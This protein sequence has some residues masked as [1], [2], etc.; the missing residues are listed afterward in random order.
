MLVLNVGLS[1][2]SYIQQPSVSGY[3]GLDVRLN[4][5]RFTKSVSV[6]GVALPPN[7]IL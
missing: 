2:V 6:S 7:N 1:N 5:I 4:A 3:K